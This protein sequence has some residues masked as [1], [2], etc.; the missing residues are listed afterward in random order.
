MV[1]DPVEP[2]LNEEFREVSEPLEPRKRHVLSWVQSAV[3]WVS[4]LVHPVVLLGRITT[5]PTDPGV[6]LFEQN[7]LGG[8]CAWVRGKAPQ[9]TTY[10]SW[11]AKS[12]YAVGAGA[13]WKAPLASPPQSEDRVFQ[14]NQKTRVDI[15]PWAPK[16]AEKR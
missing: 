13:L 5:L 3:A 9:L 1:G 15:L 7:N 8:N 16:A 11:P 12:A 14:A 6:Y 4:A 10:F 2:E